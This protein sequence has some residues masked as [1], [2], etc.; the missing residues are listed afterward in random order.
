MISLVKG[1]S[2]MVSLV[3]GKSPMVSLVKG[4]SPMVSL[5]KGKSISLY[6]K[7]YL[8]FSLTVVFLKIIL[9]EN[10]FEY[11]KGLIRSRTEG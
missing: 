11:I 2:P 7:K 1:K 6:G 5:V 3:K 4:K 10:K 8:N 9:E